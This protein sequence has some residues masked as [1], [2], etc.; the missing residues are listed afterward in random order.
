MISGY[1]IHNYIKY[2]YY[3]C[4]EKYKEFRDCWYYLQDDL[5]NHSKCWKDWRIQTRAIWFSNNHW[6]IGYTESIGSDDCVMKAKGSS[7][8]LPTELKGQWYYLDPDSKDWIEA[9]NDISLKF[10]IPELFQK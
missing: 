1:Q 8:Q 4:Y 7:D 6:R 5:I 9:G 2:S 3:A 10:D